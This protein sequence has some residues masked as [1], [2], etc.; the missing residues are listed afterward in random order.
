MLFR[1]SALEL[2]ADSDLT[3]LSLFG[4]THGISVS[5]P[6]MLA[7]QPTHVHVSHRSPISDSS[8]SASPGPSTASQIPH[9]MSF[10]PVAPYWKSSSMM[11]DSP[12]DRTRASTELVTRLVNPPW[13]SPGGPALRIGGGSPRRVPLHGLNPGNSSPPPPN[14]QTDANTAFPLHQGRASNFAFKILIKCFWDTLIQQALFF[15]NKNK[16]LSG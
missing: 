2:L 8:D 16:Q 6:T 13:R 12:R 7:Q 9:P 10:Y 3:E 15:N 1:S 14:Q 4:P 5:K 11:P